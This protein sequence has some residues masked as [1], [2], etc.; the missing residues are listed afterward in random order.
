VRDTYKG[1]MIGNK[2]CTISYDTEDSYFNSEGARVA[3]SNELVGLSQILKE[4]LPGKA[5]GMIDVGAN[6]GL[7]TL[8]MEQF[9]S[10][11]KNMLVVEPE[12]NAYQ[13]LENNMASNHLSPVLRNCGVGEKHAKLHFSS[14]PG[15]TTASHIVT[16]D[17]MINTE[18]SYDVDVER[19]DFL[20]A[21]AGMK[22]VDFIKI[23]TEGHEMQVI[24]GSIDILERFNPWVFLEFNSWTNIAFANLSPRV[25][26]EYL[27][28]TFQQVGQVRPGKNVLWIKSQQEVIAFLHENLVKHGC[29]D[30]LLLRFKQESA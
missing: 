24:K 29:V 28:D 20:V 13:L 22:Q 14:A 9:A 25:F 3:R 21:E 4:Y 26:L 1:F 16:K 8:L 18:N 19:L 10:D 30:D 27:M 11:S 12:H 15:S 5:K 6:I 7:V 23:D 2:T 17:H